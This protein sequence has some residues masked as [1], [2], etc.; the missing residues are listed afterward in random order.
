ME[1]LRGTSLYCGI[2]NTLQE[3]E[4]HLNMAASVGINAVF[5]SLN[6][7]EADSDALL[8]DFP[9][10]A[11]IAHRYGM[12]IMTDVSERTAVKFG[13]D[14]HDLQA[15]KALGVDIM[16]LDSGYTVAETAEATHNTIGMEFALN[17][18]AW[19]AEDL[20]AFSQM[21]VDATKIHFSYNYCP[22]RYTGMLP[23]QVRE[24]NDL[25]HRYGFT[26][27]GFI[28]SQTHKRIACS[29]GLPTLERHRDMDTYTA[30]REAV[31]LGFDDL[32]FGDDFAS[33]EELRLICSVKSG[34]VIFRMRRLVEGDVIDWLNGRELQQM[35]AGLAAIIRSDFCKPDSIYKGGYDGGLVAPRHAGDVCMCKSTLWRYAG[36]VQIVR[37]DL[38]ADENIGIIGRLVEEDLPLL[39]TFVRKDRFTIVDVTDA[40]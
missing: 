26:V 35:Q 34:P 30:A 15:I 40:Q 25:I 32:F 39:E 4:A 22:M 16:R 33:E 1:N 17:A 38:P 23:E 10:M 8:R 37:M 9:K 6:L 31:M 5:T 20:A 7:P 24:K 36:E 19:T 21:D 13:I 18:T 29:I 27:G 2:G 12:K 3:M 28:P 11:E 14:M